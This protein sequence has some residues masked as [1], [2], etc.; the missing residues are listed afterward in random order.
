MKSCKRRKMVVSREQRKNKAGQTYTKTQ[1]LKTQRN[2]ADMNNL[3]KLR[4][5]CKKDQIAGQ[6]PNGKSTEPA[7]SK[8]TPQYPRHLAA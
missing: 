2:N 1:L 5:Y 7:C 6:P 3:T 4:K 8:D